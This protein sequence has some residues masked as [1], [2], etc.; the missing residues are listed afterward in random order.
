MK[1]L[2]IVIILSYL[3]G[4]I[5]MGVIISRLYKGIDIRNYGSKNAGA[6][7][8]YR[9]LGPL[10]GGIVLFL[11][12][13]KGM[14]AVLFISQISLGNP[15]ANEITL[16]IIA[17]ISVIL[18]HI[19]PVY[20]G[21]KG[22]KGIATGLGVLLALIP[23]EVL[24]ASALF[25]LV[26]ALTR[27]VSL[28]S[29]LAATFISLALIFEKYYLQ[30]EIEKELIILCV[31]LTLIVFFTHRSNIKRLLNGTENKFGQKDKRM[32]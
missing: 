8:V 19:F 14:V 13:F 21:F 4:A 9:V 22:G 1:N 26:V 27:Y 31:G 29:L 20:V 28:G 2:I 11:D 15:W 30:K 18:G 17:G 16:K 23:R 7:N 12:A 10:P 32:N 25:V 24:I 6:T 3:S 5:P